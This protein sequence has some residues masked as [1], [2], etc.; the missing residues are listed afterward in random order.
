MEEWVAR[1][2]IPLLLA[3]N[4]IHHGKI[5]TKVAD[6]NQHLGLCR[7]IFV[8]VQWFA[9]VFSTE[10]GLPC[11]IRILFCLSK[12]TIIVTYDSQGER[13]MFYK[14][15]KNIV[16]KIST[17]YGPQL[18]S[19]WRLWTT[20]WK[21][22]TSLVYMV[23][24]VSFHWLD[25]IPVICAYRARQKWW[26]FTFTGCSDHKIILWEKQKENQLS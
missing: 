15:N 4:T 20:W 18:L 21:V 11:L 2:L 17:F 14:E 1:S 10:I 23:Y 24:L 7:F 25:L 19:S 22:W 9:A 13:E 16:E 3:K 6:D 8:Y 12:I 26:N 5:Q